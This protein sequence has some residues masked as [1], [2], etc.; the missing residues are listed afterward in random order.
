MTS[1]LRTMTWRNS[2][3]H[4]P[5]FSTLPSV[6]DSAPRGRRRNAHNATWKFSIT[7]YDKLWSSRLFLTWK[8][9]LRSCSKWWSGI[10]RRWWNSIRC[11]FG[12]SSLPR[13]TSRRPAPSTCSTWARLRRNR[14]YLT[15]QLQ[16]VSWTSHSWWARSWRRRRLIVRRRRL[17]AMRNKNRTRSRSWAS[18]HRFIWASS[19]RSFLNVTATT[20]ATK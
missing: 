17:P 5:Q 15:K 2:Q 1:N 8:I 12:S 19:S 20:K 14:R 10:I 4:R 7:I 13:R 16:L 11:N 9:F 3:S 6:N 18:S